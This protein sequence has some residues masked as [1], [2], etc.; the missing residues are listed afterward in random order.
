LG[1]IRGLRPLEEASPDVPDPLCTRDEGAWLNHLLSGKNEGSFK[2][3]IFWV[4][5]EPTGSPEK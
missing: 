3:E 4:K 2:M 5:A 1:N